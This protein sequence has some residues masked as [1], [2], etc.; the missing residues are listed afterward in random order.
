MIN[1]KQFLP[2]EIIKKFILIGLALLLIACKHG[3][4]LM[5]E[6]VYQL[7]NDFVYIHYDFTM[8]KYTA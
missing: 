7:L 4:Q 1:Y 6:A 3:Y 5:A 8:T 2:H